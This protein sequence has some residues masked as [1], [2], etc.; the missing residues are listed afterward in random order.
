MKGTL[1]FLLIILFGCNNPSDKKIN[2]LI[3]PVIVF[4]KSKLQKEDHK[5]FII[6]IDSSNQITTFKGENA[7]GRSLIDTYGVGDTIIYILNKKQ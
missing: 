3:P 6:L 4:A 7:L 2:K 1:I 5:S